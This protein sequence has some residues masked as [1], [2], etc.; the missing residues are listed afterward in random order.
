VLTAHL[1]GYDLLTVSSK[2]WSAMTP[3]QQTAFQAAADKAIDWSQAEHLKQ[4]GEL[5]VS[6]KEKGLQVYAPDVNAFRSFAQKK[7]LESDIAKSWPAGM[8]DKINAL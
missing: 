5:A 7:Y 3:E 6:F 8:V 4:E 1:V 2:V